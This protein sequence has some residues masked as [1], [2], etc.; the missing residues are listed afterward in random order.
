MNPAALQAPRI[1]RIARCGSTNDV[2][3]ERAAAGSPEGTVVWADAQDAGR[4]RWG[5]TWTSPPGKDLLFS[6]LLAPPETADAL[7]LVPM[8]AA[9]AVADTLDTVGLPQV[10]VRWPNDVLA[11]DR[12]IAGILAER[13]PSPDAVVLGIGVNVDSRPEDRPD[14][15]RGTTTSCST[16]RHPLDRSTLLA[17]ILGRLAF[18]LAQI[19]EAPGDLDRDWTS[20]S[21]LIGQS[22]EIDPVDGLP[23]AIGVAREVSILRGVVLETTHGPLRIPPMRIERIR[24]FPLTPS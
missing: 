5:R 22:V 16:L 2:C 20:R 4:G 15:L 14:D 3:W 8:A 18:R 24:R 7:P 9:V 13:R 19:R 12:K 17:D 21:G 1:E 23:P 6:V 11:S 10:R